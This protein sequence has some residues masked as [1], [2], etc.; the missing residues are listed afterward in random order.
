[1]GKR[2]SRASRAATYAMSEQ[3]SLL[4]GPEPAAVFA[5]PLQWDE[6]S[7]YAWLDVP[8][9]V[10][11]LEQPAI[12]WANDAAMRFL[13]AETREELFARDQSKIPPAVRL[14]IEGALKLVGQ[15]RVVREQITLYPRDIPVTATILARGVHLPDG[16]LAILLVGQP[17]ASNV[18]PTA[19]RGIEAMQHTPMRV[20]LHRL[21]D[22]VALM[23][24]PAAAQ[25]F[26]AAETLGGGV[27]FAALF[28]DL[29]VARRVLEQV[30]RGQTFSGE[31]ELNTSSGLRWHALDVRPVRDPVTGLIAVQLNARDISDVKAYQFAI[32]GARDAAEAASRAKSVFLANM[33]HEIRTPMNGVLGLTE[34]VLGSSTLDAKNREFLELAHESAHSLMRIIDDLLD[35]S[36]I[37]AQKLSLHQA[38]FVVREMLDAAVA[39]LAVQ[40]RGKALVFEFGVDAAVPTTL[41]GD[42][43]RL[44]QVLTNLLGNA[45]KFTAR[46]SV[47]VA[48]RLADAV[49]DNIAALRLEVSDTG[50]GMTPEQIEQAFEPFTQADSSITRRYGGT[51]LGLAIVQRL[52]NLMDGRVDVSSAPGEGSCFGVTVKLSVAA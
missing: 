6:L 20:S 43:G 37:E 2:A 9:W 47:R 5:V 19:L 44:R 12:R 23:L 33:S 40:A 26:G 8:A 10:F 21:S 18:E 4:S 22:G 42:E 31:A 49:A 7:H 35:L 11:D 38:P 48:V 24:N 29:A 39:P 16:R 50:I 36:K 1:M 14:R 46:G 32:E 52:V 34:L 15:G 17:L 25:A 30:K 41:V 28:L 13:H 27:E 45:V 51:G 3:P